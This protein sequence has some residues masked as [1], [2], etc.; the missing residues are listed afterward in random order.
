LTEVT[1]TVLFRDVPDDMYFVETDAPFLTPYPYRGKRNRPEYVQYIIQHIAEIK[2]KSPNEIA[3]QTTENA[4]YF[5]SLHKNL[6][7]I[8]RVK[9]FDQNIEMKF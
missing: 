5:F 9:Y 1:T 6:I 4:E 3:R 8:M 7:R 2:G